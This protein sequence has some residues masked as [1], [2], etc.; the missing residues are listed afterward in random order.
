MNKKKAVTILIVLATIVLAGIAIFTAVRLYQLRQKAVA[1]TAPESKPEAIAPKTKSCTQLA[2]TISA[3]E[4][5]TPS[6]TAT[7]TTTPTATPTTTPTTTPTASPTASPTSSPIAQA[8]PSPTATSQPELPEAGITWP[9]L[10]SAGA[11]IILLII[12]LALAI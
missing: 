2:F 12:S 5:P 9:T 11:G 6:P 3:Q 4:S 8:S 10:L 7:P 1:P